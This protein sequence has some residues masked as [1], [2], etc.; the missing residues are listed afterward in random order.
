[1]TFEI[2]RPGRIS[3][4]HTSPARLSKAGSLG[5]G[6]L[7][8][9]SAGMIAFGLNTPAITVRSLYVFTTDYS[10]LG[11]IR[12]LFQGG[13]VL[14][15]ILV[16]VVSVIF[17][18]TK[19]ALGLIALSTR[20]IWPHGTRLLILALSRLSKWSMLDVFAVALAV[21]VLNGKLFTNADL[22]TGLWL[23]AGGVLLSTFA[24]HRLRQLSA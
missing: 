14:L 6:A 11:G 19:I 22:R 13:Q 5:Y 12:S 17:P 8:V 21:I 7:L 18:L 10:I 20:T 4:A 15:G 24:L 9:L 3:P 23:F 1:M 16:L 2:S